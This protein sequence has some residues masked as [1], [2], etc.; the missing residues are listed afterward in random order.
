[1]KLHEL[2]LNTEVRI[3]DEIYY[4]KWIDGMYGKW[5]DVIWEPYNYWT[6]GSTLIDL[7]IKYGNKI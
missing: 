1:M 2:R 4:F 7:W 5:E 3:N 6:A